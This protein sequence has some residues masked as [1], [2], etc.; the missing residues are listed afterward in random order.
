[1]ASV[2]E[3]EKRLQEKTLPLYCQTGPSAGPEGMDERIPPGF[4]GNEETSDLR[5][6]LKEL[7]DAD[8]IPL[9]AD[10]A[11]AKRILKEDRR[12]TKAEAESIGQ[13]YGN[14][15]SRKDRKKNE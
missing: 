10:K 4:V 12:Y 8:A 11:A 1:M 5:E 6:K 15:E 14:Y 3:L 7:L 13:M 9:S 2:K